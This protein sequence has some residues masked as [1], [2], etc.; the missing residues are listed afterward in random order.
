MN[1]K[2]KILTVIAN[3]KRV[4]NDGIRSMTGYGR[5]QITRVLTYLIREGLIEEVPIS[6]DGMVITER[7]YQMKRKKNTQ[8]ELFK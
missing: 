7:G 5:Y 6:I 1:Q 3:H 8:T 4:S 2:Q